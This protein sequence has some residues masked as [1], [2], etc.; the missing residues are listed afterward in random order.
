[1]FDISICNDIITLSSVDIPFALILRV[2][3]GR[4]YA[5]VEKRD[6]EDFN[7]EL[8]DELDVKNFIIADGFYGYS[9]IVVIS[10]WI[11][12]LGVRCLLLDENLQDIMARHHDFGGM[13]YEF[14]CLYG[15]CWFLGCKV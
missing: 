10:S 15:A 1:M 7:L 4:D 12:V 8:I 2:L 3:F 11:F 6:Y 14:G 9:T 13:H 5:S